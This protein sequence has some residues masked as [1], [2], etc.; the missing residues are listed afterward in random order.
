MRF[1]EAETKYRELEEQLLRGE[2]KEEEF[3]VQAAQLRTV[4]GEGRRW[5]ISART[6][7]WLVHDGQQW[8]FATPPSEP[9]DVEAPGAAVGDEGEMVADQARAEAAPQ[10]KRSL[11]A[12]PRF[13]VVGIAA[14]LL[15][16]CLAGGGISAWVF[17]LRD[18]GEEATPVA[19]AP[20]DVPLV[21]TYTPRPATP[22]YTPTFTPT[23]S[24]TPTPTNTPMAT[25]TPTPTDTP[26]PTP[27]WTP[28]PPT[29]TNSPTPAVTEASTRVTSVA[30]V[31]PTASSTPTP[32]P[33]SG[34]TYTVR[35][36]DTLFEIA[37]EFGVSVRALAEANGIDNT[38]LIRPG[39]VLV[40]PVPGTTPQAPTTTPTPT[41]TP[42][43]VRTPTTTGTTTPRTTPTPTP[44]PTRATRTPTPTPT[45]SGPTAT[46]RPSN[47][48]RPT[49]TPTAQPA[50]LS[51][52]IAFTV[53]NPFVNKYELYVSLI[54]GS[55]R[56]LLGEGYRQPQF[57]QDGNLLAVNG[58]GSPNFEH[59]ITMD[60]SGGNK[61][62]VSNY[63]ED[64]YPSWSPDGAIVA[65]SSTSWGDGQSRL[66]IVN[67]MF[68]KQ[69]DWIKIG[70]TEI[71]GQYPFWMADGRVVYQ[72]CD[73]LGDQAACGLYWVGAGGGAYQRLTTD[74]SDTAPAGSGN[75]V[76]FMSARDGNWEV[77]AINMDGSGL[78][79]LTE[80]NAL[81]GLPTWSPNGQSIAFVSNRD[82]NWGIW[83]MN[84]NGSSQRKLFDLG[85]GYGSGAY[86]WTK[87]RISWAP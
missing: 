64:S 71:R 73:F 77:Y 45:T 54:D 28:A 51:G 15:L 70:T 27:S 3:L 85:G 26:P 40:I 44:T 33:P 4:D 81:D 34:Q 67:D 29:T 46:P 9:E 56:N 32:A 17:L 21:Q 82:G 76:A 35:A 72:G 30:A 7:R 38:S 69:Q 78:V 66:G 48:P 39:M 22:T 24:R 42:I 14:L 84:A 65:Y 87:E 55:G 60:P 50:T 25:N 53:W 52:K 1:D 2:L 79:R 59:L 74:Q 13:L 11:A 6:G 63:S 31:S 19:E 83:V 80:N 61:A 37:L 23:P 10:R 86:D 36:G 47:T 8:V 18:W 57:R 62:E 41:W 16:G 43:V 58:D 5:M 68:G 12:L 75:R 20:T 49:A